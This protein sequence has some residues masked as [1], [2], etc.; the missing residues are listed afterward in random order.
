[1]NRTAVFVSGA[2]TNM[3]NLVKE[4]QE[5]RIPCE[6]VLVICDKPGAAAIEKAERLGVTVRLVDR[7]MFTAKHEFEQEILWYLAENRIEWILL[8]GF[9]RILSP[10]FVGRYIGRIINIH[11]SLLPEFPGAHGI[12]DAF[13]AKVKETGVTVHFVDASVDTGPV[14]LKRKVPVF[15]GDSLETLA[16]RVHAVEYEIFPEALR[17]VFSGKVKSPG[18]RS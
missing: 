2:G 6:I 12:R 15:A 1:M 9:M 17:L 11:P 4:T 8:A 16:A 13:D 3:E 7:K 14:I 10:E 18:V 5:G